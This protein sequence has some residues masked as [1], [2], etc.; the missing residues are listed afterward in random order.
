MCLLYSVLGLIVGVAFLGVGVVCMYGRFRGVADMQFELWKLKCRI[1]T[2]MPGVMFALLG[3][4]VIY[5]TR[6]M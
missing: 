1:N 3:L 4:L 6:P 2:S 5:V